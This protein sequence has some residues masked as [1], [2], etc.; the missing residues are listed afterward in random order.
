MK[1]SK[2]TFLK[3][4]FLILVKNERW[5]HSPKNIDALIYREQRRNMIACTWSFLAV[6]IVGLLFVG[7]STTKTT[8]IKTD[9]AI[10]SDSQVKKSSELTNTTNLVDKSI[11]SNNTSIGKTLDITENEIG[12]VTGKLTIFDTSLPVDAKTGKPPAKSE[13]VWTNK[14]TT[15]KSE[16]QKSNFVTTDQKKND[17]KIDE[18]SVSKNKSD[19][20]ANVKAKTK[21]ED[22]TTVKK[23]PN[24]SLILLGVLGVTVLLIFVFKIPVV[25]LFVK[26]FSFVRK[27]LGKQK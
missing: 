7:C 2:R 9:Q 20:S 16:N 1:T 12:E 13:L 22:T 6:F 27:I 5:L 26:L 24:M 21:T 15:Q 8:K 18:K 10:S 4:L 14:K 17:L 3:T 19:S 11:I 25:E 23:L